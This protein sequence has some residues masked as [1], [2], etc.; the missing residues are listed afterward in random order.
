MTPR[1]PLWRLRSLDAASGAQ[2]L[3]ARRPDASSSCS[4]GIDRHVD[5]LLYE[6]ETVLGEPAIGEL[7]ELV[8]CSLEP[9]DDVWRR[10]QFF[11]D[12]LLRRN[13]SLRILFVEP[14]ADPLHDL[15][16]RHRPGG[17]SEKAIR[18][19]GRLVTFRPLKP[20]PR[21]LGGIS[22]AAL[23]RQVL[24]AARRM[25]FTRPVLWIND[26]TYAPLIAQT[27]WPSVYDVTDDWLLAPFGPRE[28][29]RL[30][31]TRRD[32]PRRRDE[33]VVCSPAL[34]E[35]RG[36]GR[37]V[38]LIPNGVD[39]EHFRRPRP[40]PADLP[41]PPAAVYVGSLHEARLDVEL[42]EEL[43]RSLE[44]LQVVLVGPDS[45]D[46]ELA[47]SARSPCRTSTSL[48]RDPTRTSPP[49]SSMRM[50]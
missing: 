34:A 25:G 35:T 45:L 20:L 49:T 10:N 31:T 12:A 44:T 4:F 5:R 22:D 40:R 23:Q 15:S 33:V 8:V 14:P 32:R 27:G 17:R 42:L 6:Y 9:W 16:N 38:A 18:A 30:R 26:V 7:R 11:V 39:V 13:P 29:E 36:A 48:A 21:R 47:A 28:L 19:D 2:A 50:S 37:D 43:A 46:D 41:S 1:P 3:S 24:G